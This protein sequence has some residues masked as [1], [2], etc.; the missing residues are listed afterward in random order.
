MPSVSSTVT[1]KPANIMVTGARDGAVLVDFGIAR[2]AGD[3]SLTGQ[4]LPRQP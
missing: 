2:I 4:R 3:P 1:L